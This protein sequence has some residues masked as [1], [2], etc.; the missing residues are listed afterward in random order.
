MKNALGIDIGYGHTKWVSMNDEGETKRGSFMSVA[1]LTT[2]ERNADVT[3]MSSLKTVTVAVD[4]NNYVVGKDAHLEADS[5]YSRSRLANFSQ[6]PGYHALMLGA[7]SISGLRQIDQLVIGLPLSTAGTYRAALNQ[8]YR[9]EHLIGSTNATRKIEVNIKNVNVNSQP[10][11]AMVYAVSLNPDLR[12]STNLVIDIGYFTMDFLVCEGM[13]PSYARSGAVQGGMSSYYD[14]L[15]GLVVEK[16]VA[17]G[18]PS[19]NGVDHFRLEQTISGPVK[20]SDGS[21]AYSLQVGNKVL[22]ISDCVHRAESKLVEYIDR[23]TTTVGGKAFGSI[24]NVVLAGG[25]ALLLKPVVEK[26]M[27]HT[28]D[29]YAIENAQYAVAN[30]YAQFAHAMLMRQAVVTE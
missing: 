19:A 14:H 26:M 17:N 16:L 8:K 12:K 11:G 29:Y 13:K 15:E 10:A 23:M 28:H 1:P 2:R 22:D 25:G 9:G 6:T 20:G 18:L 27:G 21:L 4:G 24:T 3:G 30:G 7:I 5:N